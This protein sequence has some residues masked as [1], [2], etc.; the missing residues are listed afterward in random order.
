MNASNLR[1]ELQLLLCIARRDL[2]SD[3]VLRLRELL[4][5]SLDW[6][7]L[8]TLAFEHKL[9]PL[10]ALHVISHGADLVPPAVLDQLR[11]ELVTNRTSNLYLLNE[12]GRVLSRFESGG[13]SA[14]TFKGP[15]LAQLV[16][17]DTGLRQ[18]GDLDILID[19]KDFHRAAEVLRE[20]DYEMEPQLTPA[21]LRSHLRFHCEIQFINADRFRVVDLHWGITPKIF[22][23]ALT[24]GD[25]LAN[26]KTVSLGGYSI[27]T[28]TDEDL[29][30]YL[31]VHAAKHHFRKLEW[32]TTIAEFIRKN[33]TLSWAAVVARARRAKAEPIMCLAL[34][35]AESLYD[36]T[37]PEVFVDL[38]N[39]DDMKRTLAKVRDYLLTNTGPPNPLQAFRFN[40][41]FLSRKDAYRSL[42][43]YVL[44]PTISDWQAFSIPDAL[45]PAYYLLRPMRLLTKY[46]GRGED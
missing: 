24:A 26:R 46:G 29:I 27:Q 36:V 22:P 3:V 21:Q 30:F 12:L 18:A 34:M 40:L 16:Y 38:A 43:R 7:D 28:M 35:L 37:V 6:D 33:Q 2:D 44:V 17:E 15:V 1:A 42:A 10:L 31:S 5:Q 25:F 19:V 14:L 45:Y 13:I 4:M 20:L 32:T 23:L 8:R 41:H 9:L 11:D 39:S